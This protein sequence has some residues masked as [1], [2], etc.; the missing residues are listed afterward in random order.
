LEPVDCREGN[1]MTY[2]INNAV[3]TTMMYSSQVPLKA[4]ENHCPYC[5]GYAIR[6]IPRQ[7]GEKTQSHEDCSHC[8]GKGKRSTET[9]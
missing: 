9:A 2:D 8:D 1:Q 4:G 6:P 7:R 5:S 3:F